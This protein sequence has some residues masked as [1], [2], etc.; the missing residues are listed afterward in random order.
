MTSSGRIPFLRAQ[1]LI[2]LVVPDLRAL[3]HVARSDAVDSDAFAAELQRPAAHEV[4]LPRLRR[5]VGGVRL[6]GLEPR[7]A[8][9]VDD[10]AAGALR[11][12]DPRDLASGQEIPGEIDLE[13]LRP[14]A[15]GKVD[16]RKRGAMPAALTRKSTPPTD[17]TAAA[18]ARSTDTSSVTSQRTGRKRP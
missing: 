9:Q 11:D 6:A 2:V 17:A 15:D 3:E 16:E 7:L 12:E 5:V 1:T 4:D 10:A 13:R 18:N 14:G 8:G